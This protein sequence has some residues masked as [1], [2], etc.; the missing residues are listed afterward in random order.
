MAAL[1]SAGLFFWY[2][3]R[4]LAR[5]MDNEGFT[6]VE[7]NHYR[8]V[9]HGLTIDFRLTREKSGDMRTDCVK[10]TLTLPKSGIRYRLRREGLAWGILRTVG[11]GEVQLEDENFDQAFWIECEDKDKL[12]EYLQPQHRAALIHVFQ[13]DPGTLEADKIR[14]SRSFMHPFYGRRYFGRLA[15]RLVEAAEIFAGVAEPSQACLKAA[16][17]VARVKTRKFVPWSLLFSVGIPALLSVLA[18]ATGRASDIFQLICVI[19]LCVSFSALLG[20]NSTRLILQS[21][22]AF[23]AVTAVAVPFVALATK[24][25]YGDWRSYS[26]I[27]VGSFLLALLS[28][29]VRHFL[30]SQE[31][32]VKRET[33]SYS[34]L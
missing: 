3:R 10:A 18:S 24:S 14:L 29:G 2:K 23:L 27:F 19:G 25:L 1:N 32:P 12:S 17:S 15:N 7:N 33:E 9:L 4:Q 31:V 34:K 13:D 11:Q 16:K 22:F 26:A 28:W 21:Y 20:L 5:L 30:K 8:R 6:L